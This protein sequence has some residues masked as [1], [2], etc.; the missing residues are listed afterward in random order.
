LG[1]Q[2]DLPLFEEALGR[3]ELGPERFLLAGTFGHPGLM[4]EV[5]HAMESGG[6]AVAAAAANSFRKLT[7]LDVNT[8]H[9]V[10]VLSTQDLEE[11]EASTEEVH[12]PDAVAARNHWGR[13]KGA[14]S[15]VPRLCMGTDALKGWTQEWLLGLPLDARWEHALRA[16]FETGQGGGVF[17]LERFPQLPG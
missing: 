10:A 11:A 9:R 3:R 1:G 16:H 17:A 6:P 15:G 2:A 5:L 13:L 4:E 7:G 12:I 14:L 8:A